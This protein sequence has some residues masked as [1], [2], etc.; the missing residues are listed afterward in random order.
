MSEKLTN[1]NTIVKRLKYGKL[2]T[3]TIDKIDGAMLSHHGEKYNLTFFSDRPVVPSYTELVVDKT[4]GQV[5]NERFKEDPSSLNFERILTSGVELDITSMKA[6]VTLMLEA[7][8][9]VENK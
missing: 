1:K 7:I 2:P 6:V 8:N 5:I 3:F 9:K 4:N